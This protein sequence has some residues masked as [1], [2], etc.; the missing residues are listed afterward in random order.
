M[1]WRLGVL[2]IITGAVLIALFLPVHISVELPPLPGRH[3]QPY[4]YQASQRSMWITGA[5][6]VAGVLAVAGLIAHRIVRQHRNS[7]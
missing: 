5:V 7:R 6:M 4:V 3:P 2:A 1:W